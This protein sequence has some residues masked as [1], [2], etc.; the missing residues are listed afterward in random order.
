MTA[1]ITTDIIQ[2]K[3]YT[4]R[5]QKVMLD[6]DLAELYQVSTKQL[7]QQVKRNPNRFPVDFIFVL[8][9]QEKDELVTKCDHLRNLKYS[10][11]LPTAFTEHGALML[12]TVL[13]S[14][15]ASE[16]STKII[17]GFVAMR[18]NLQTKPSIQKELQDIQAHLKHH[19]TKHQET[20]AAIKYLLEQID[21]NTNLLS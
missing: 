10:S 19:D 6:R 4:I 3:I 2:S 9:D 14:K 16:I 13:K 15:L 8:T 21:P 17:R 7:K 20:F 12:S 1:L 18:K 5:G 11:V